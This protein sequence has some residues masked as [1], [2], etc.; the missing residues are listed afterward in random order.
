MRPP[1][2]RKNWKRKER[3]CD[4][5]RHFRGRSI[6]FPMCRAPGS[7]SV[8]QVQG[9]ICRAGRPGVR[10]SPPAA[11]PAEPGR[12]DDNFPMTIH[13]KTP[14][15]IEK[16]REAGRLAAE[17]LQVVAPHVNPGVTTEALAPLPH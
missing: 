7:P 10:G 2:A 8:Q 4:V 12:I 11:C 3:K 13:L 1:Y 17:V 5:E 15:E 9:R 6:T 14:E 16:L